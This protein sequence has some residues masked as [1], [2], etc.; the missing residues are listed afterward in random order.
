[1]AENWASTRVGGDNLYRSSSI[2]SEKVLFLVQVMK[3]KGEKLT[4]VKNVSLY[5]FVNAD[6]N[7]C[8]AHA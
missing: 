4:I 3:R 2:S 6:V 7:S 8:F 1:M 5:F